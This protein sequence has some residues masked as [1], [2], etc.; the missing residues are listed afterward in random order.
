MD[1]FVIVTTLLLIGIGL[2]Q[3]RI[4]KTQQPMPKGS[5]SSHAQWY[6]KYWPVLVMFLILPLNWIPYFLARSRGAD[7]PIEYMTYR[8]ALIPGSPYASNP[9]LRVDTEGRFFKEYSGDHYLAA[10]AFRLRSGDAKDARNLQK[11]A[12]FDIRDETISMAIPLDIDFLNSIGKAIGTNYALLIV[13]S[14][15]QMDQ[16]DTL[17]QAERLGV[18]VVEVRGGPP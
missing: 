18:K 17:R 3:V 12:S 2:W 8:G 15:I 10:V 14:K 1:I 4:M 6:R 5:K 13:P 11:S 9:F 7:A 16:F